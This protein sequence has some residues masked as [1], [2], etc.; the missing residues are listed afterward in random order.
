MLNM[1][2]QISAYALQTEVL[3]KFINTSVSIRD[4]LYEL[5]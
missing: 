1:P 5:H 2:N 4:E 3:K